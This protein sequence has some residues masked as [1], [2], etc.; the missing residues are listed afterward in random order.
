MS[1]AQLAGI[2]RPYTFLTLTPVHSQPPS[3]PGT[4]E[5]YATPNSALITPPLLPADALGPVAGT[6]HRSSS[7][8]SVG[9]KQRFLRLLPVLYGNQPGDDF[10]IED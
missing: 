5:T 7:V 1:T 6:G 10:A 4:P 3:G 9:D 2:R 8:S